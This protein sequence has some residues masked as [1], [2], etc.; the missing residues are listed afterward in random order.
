MLNDSDVPS[1]TRKSVSYEDRSSTHKP[2]TPEMRAKVATFLKQDYIA[3]ANYTLGMQ[4]KIGWTTD[5]GENTGMFK[6]KSSIGSTQVIGPCSLREFFNKPTALYWAYSAQE[7]DKCRLFPFACIFKDWFRYYDNDPNLKFGHFFANPIQITSTGPRTIAG[8]CDAHKT[9]YDRASSLQDRVR[10]C[11]AGEAH[12]DAWPNSQHYKLLPL[13]RAIL[14]VLDEIPPNPGARISLERE[15]QR[16]NVLII[17]T[18]DED[19]LSAPINFDTIRSQSLPL[20]RS[21]TDAEDCESIIRV[22]LRTA[23]QFILDLQR[24]EELAFPKLSCSVSDMSAN[25]DEH[26]T[27]IMREAEEKG[28]SNVSSVRFAVQ[29]IKEEESGEPCCGRE[30]DFWSPMWN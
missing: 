4:T 29:R 12:L 2:L 14:I 24:R 6:L 21:D 25:A 30:F 23:V 7:R 5:F 20:A 3:S 1:E 13:C 9:L 19:S 8:I 26:V 27:G 17:R 16:Q 22:S 10:K 28:S 18:G 11:E 15:V